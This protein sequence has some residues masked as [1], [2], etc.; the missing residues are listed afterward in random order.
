[1]VS[2]G[3]LDNEAQL[4]FKQAAISAQHGS[5]AP[6][7]RS[8]IFLSDACFDA[9]KVAEVGWAGVRHQIRFISEQQI[10]VISE[11]HIRFK[12]GLLSVAENG[13]VEKLHQIAI[14]I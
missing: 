6:E 2:R 14:Y 13:L 1:M 3:S 8:H 10:R 11:H 4:L 9:C 7:G 12:L 5:L